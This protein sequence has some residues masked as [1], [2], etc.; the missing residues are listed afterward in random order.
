LVKDSQFQRLGSAMPFE[1]LKPAAVT[2]KDGAV[3]HYVREGRGDPLIFL[4]GSIGDWRY[5]ENQ[6]P[7]F[8]PCFDCIAMSSRFSYPNQNRMPSPHHNALSDADDVLSVMDALELESV[9]LLGTSYGGIAA[10]AAAVNAEKRIKAVV[11]VEPAM[12]KF[13][14]MFDDTAAAVEEFRRSTIEPARAAFARGDNL[15]AV[16][17]LTGGI[18]VTT[19]DALPTAV[20]QRRLQNIEAVR[21]I[22]LSSN[23]YPSIDPE[24]LRQLRVPHLLV[25][26]A[27]T[28]PVFQAVFTGLNRVAENAEFAVI[29][30]TDHDLPVGK[31][32]E[33]NEV[34]IRFFRSGSVDLNR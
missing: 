28:A 6:W 13:G 31:P 24:A 15:K 5:W 33:L 8:V 26:G 25:K 34:A 22:N 17:Y 30:D 4:H 20:R 23:G 2:L 29:P 7:D 16:E 12:L 19:L 9:Y 14:E 10:L 27:D 1:H 21:R 18:A 32:R 11:A 3:I